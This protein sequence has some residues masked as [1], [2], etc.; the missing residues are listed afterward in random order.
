MKHFRRLKH[1]TLR[2]RQ[3][4]FF[5]F[6]YI[7]EVNML[8]PTS[9]GGLAISNYVDIVDAFK[10]TCKS[11]EKLSIVIFGMD[12]HQ[13][14]ER[15]WDDED[16][17]D[18]AYDPRYGIKRIGGLQDFPALKQVRLPYQAIVGHDEEGD[19]VSVLS[20]LLPP[21]LTKL[22]VER[23]SLEVWIRLQAHLHPRKTK[24]GSLR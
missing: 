3:Y 21:N 17:E 12:Y 24:H 22:V 7:D 9:A 4:N 1:M 19:E 13:D 6:W 11:L 15:V 16:D 2:I 23:P 14:P 20:K 18:L 5:D 10:S 8:D